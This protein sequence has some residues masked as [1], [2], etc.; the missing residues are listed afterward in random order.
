[1]YKIPDYCKT[2]YTV[3]MRYY[4]IRLLAGRAVVVLNARFSLVPARGMSA[5]VQRC[6]HG[7]LLSG[8]GLPTAHGEV[9][10]IE[11]EVL[12]RAEQAK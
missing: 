3:R 12:Y 7:L 4:L 2:S 11:S 9:L 6:P 1:M 10:R 8:T 5:Y